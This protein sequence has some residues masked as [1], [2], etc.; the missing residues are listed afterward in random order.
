MHP[1][2]RCRCLAAIL[3]LSLTVPFFSRADEAKPAAPAAQAGELSRACIPVAKNKK[4]HEGFLKDKEEQLKKGPIQLVFVGDSITDGWRKP[5]AGEGDNRKGGKEIWD[6]A[7]GQYN[8]LNLGI[9][10]EHTEDVLW[11]LQNGEIDGIKPKLFVMM[12]GTN[13]LAHKP[14]QTPQDV[15]AGIHCLVK[16]IEEKQPQ[17]KILLLGIFPRSPEPT[18]KYRDEI[19]QVNDA[20]SKLDGSDPHVKYLDIGSKFLEADG[21]LPK[22][23]MP[24]SL[25]PN[26]HGYQIWADAIKPTVDAMM[27]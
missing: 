20:V 6:A 4:R 22:S 15:I 17:A 27:K 9:S 2:R 5:A 8:P 11:R 21:K 18:G 26:T 14:E 12:I 3:S 7:F 24:D 19:K 16:T 10:G 13:N 25:H 23:I 1:T